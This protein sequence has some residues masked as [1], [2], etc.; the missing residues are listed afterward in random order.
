MRYLPM[1]NRV[2]AEML[3]EIA[4]MLSVDETATSRFEVRAYKNAALTLLSLQQPIE[5]VYKGGGAKAVMKLPGIGAGIAGKIEEFIKTG[6]MKKY[7]ELK[8]R[9]PINFR[10]LL[11]LEGMGAKK[12]VMLYRK[13]GV[14]GLADLKS[15]V[16]AHKVSSLEGFGERSEE[17]LRRSMQLLESSKGRILL[18]DAL[19]EAESIVRLLLSAKVV[20]KAVIAGSTRRMKETVGDIDILAISRTAGKAM[21]A[22]TSLGDVE[23]VVS[24]GP[25]RTTVALRI[26]VTC[27]LRVLPPESFGAAQQYFIGSKQHNIGLRKIAIRRGYKL[28]EYGLY[29]RSGKIIA[30]EDE[31]EIYERLG[32]QYVP[33]EM[34]EARGE[35]GLS[36]LHKIPELVELGDL[37][38]DLH[39]HTR[40]T[41]GTSTIEEMAEAAAGAGLAYIAA[42][43][44]T[45]SLRVAKGMNDAQ[46]AAFNNKVDRL[47]SS[48]GEKF[49]VLKGAEVDILKD[50]RLDLSSTTLGAMDCIV[51]SV[52]TFFKMGREEMT[53]RV[54]RAVGSGM[55]D[56][57]GHPTGRLIGER[58]P[59]H[60]DLD[61]VAQACEDN[62][63]ALEINSWPNRLDLNDTNILLASKY[64]VMFSI[65]SDAHSTTHYQMLRYGVGTARRGWLTK[66]R[67]L[68]ALPLK[69]LEKRLKR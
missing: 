40:E 11:T 69:A 18:G 61:A 63:V 67:V 26:G 5:E 58:E 41:D 7:E 9:Y 43:N 59:Y 29:A 8:L 50:G 48:F 1:Q 14:K 25:T 6:R 13:L 42:T 62:N 46:F 38:G 54:V 56:V 32:M 10:E 52:H 55:V 22:F 60:V 27:D 24:R 19:P 31:R 23:S 33:P 34:R 39:T 51:G 17:M 3:D 35:I 21:E 15:A 53:E 65:D 16:E 66:E 57:L 4:D 30:S 47:N 36:L 68:N 2:I 49:R 64:K 44:H 37:K 20:D 45:K 12:A 28:N